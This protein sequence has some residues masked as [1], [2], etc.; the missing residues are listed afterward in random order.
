VS[1]QSRRALH[2]RQS[3]SSTVQAV[4]ADERFS[5][6]ISKII[7]PVDHPEQIFKVNDSVKVM[8]TEINLETARVALESCE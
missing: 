3:F 5:L 6:Q 2:T 1:I 4:E 8:L 7:P